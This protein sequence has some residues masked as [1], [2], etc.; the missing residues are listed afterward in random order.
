MEDVLDQH[1]AYHSVTG[2]KVSLC[3]PTNLLTNIEVIRPR[4]SLHFLTFWIFPDFSR[5]RFL[6]THLEK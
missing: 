1:M 3:I 6:K 5:R 2:I 4:I